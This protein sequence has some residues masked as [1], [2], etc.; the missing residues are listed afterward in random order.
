MKDKIN[1]KVDTTEIELEIKTLEDELRKK[2]SAKGRILTE[3][4]DLDPDDKHYI[5]RRSDLDE[6]LYNMYDKINSIEDQLEEARCRKFTVESEKL[7]ADNIYSILLNFEKLYSK[8]NDE[9]K[10]ELMSIL[11][12]EINIYEEPTENGQW[13][14]EIKFSLPLTI[15]NIQSSWDKRTHVSAV[16]KFS[17]G[18]SFPRETLPTSSIVSLFFTIGTLKLKLMVFTQFLSLS[19]SG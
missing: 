14:K 3:I 13:L 12:T 4:D 9:E 10:R 6:R 11:V 7:K 8:M 5:R 2:L 18:M 16:I 19:H 15:E 17:K 1:S